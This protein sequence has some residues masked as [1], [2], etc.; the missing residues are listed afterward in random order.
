MINYTYF[1]TAIFS[2][3]NNQLG[4]V[5]ERGL[6]QESV[7]PPGGGGVIPSRPGGHNYACTCINV[8]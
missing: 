3:T 6:E 8:C 7:L 1:R 4:L 2:N 5:G